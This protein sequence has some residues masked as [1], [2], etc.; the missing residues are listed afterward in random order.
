VALYIE[1]SG[2]AVAILQGGPGFTSRSVAPIGELLRDRFRVVRFE[3]A[4][5]TVSGLVDRIDT[6]R[7]EL[8][9]E[10]WFVLGHSWGAAMA[11]LYAVKY[12]ERTRALILA[13]PMEVSSHFSEPPDDASSTEQPAGAD[14]RFAQEHDPDVAEALWEDLEDACPDATG[15]GYDLTAVARQIATPALVLLGERDAIDRR[16]G[17]LWAE[18][19]NARIVSLPDSGHWSFL[20]QPQEFQRQVAEFLL[21]QVAGRAMAA[22]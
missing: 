5:S 17:K 3:H 8:G 12:P 22:A 19:T 9:E 1:G 18:L 21:A 7:A 6:V 13:H 2:P 10:R 15:E 14:E 16:S 4:D 20:E 11:A